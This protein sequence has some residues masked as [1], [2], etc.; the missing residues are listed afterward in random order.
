MDLTYQCFQER[1]YILKKALKDAAEEGLTHPDDK[2]V[3][4]LDDCLGWYERKTIED[5]LAFY[6][7]QLNWELNY[8]K[9]N[10]REEDRRVTKEEKK[11]RLAVKKVN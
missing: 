5:S 8:Y 9:R 4:D 1:A 2:I 3:A 10:L 6:I 11:R 7:R